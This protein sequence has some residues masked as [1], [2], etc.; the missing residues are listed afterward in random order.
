VNPKLVTIATFQFLNEAEWYKLELETA[1]LTV[2]LA[3]AE[4]VNMDWILGNAVGGIKLQVPV[5]D[6]AKGEEIVERIHLEKKHR[7]DTTGDANVCLACGE[8]MPDDASSCPQC[9]WSYGKSEDDP[10]SDPE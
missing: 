1:G 8:P 6:V 9:G 4:M 5:A 3:D 10:G 7:K 2:F